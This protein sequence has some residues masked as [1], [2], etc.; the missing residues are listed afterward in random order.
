VTHGGAVAEKPEQQHTAS[1]AV[2]VHALSSMPTAS[3]LLRQI[4]SVGVEDCLQSQGDH[5]LH[6]P[7]HV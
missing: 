3:L 4:L 6:G 5:T 1:L 2:M 7:I